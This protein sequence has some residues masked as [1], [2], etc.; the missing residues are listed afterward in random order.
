MGCRLR[1]SIAALAIVLVGGLSLR[2][3]DYD[4]FLKSDSGSARFYLNT[5]TGEFR[6][7]DSQKKLDVTGTGMLYFPSLGP[8][9]FSFAGTAPGY[10]WVSVSLKIYGTAATG[11]LAAFPEGEKVR[12][13]VSN[14]YDRNTE[15]DQPVP[16]HRKTPP[17]PPSIETIKPTPSEVTPCPPTN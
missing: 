16:K 3:A 10:D 14:L 13:I 17:P 8:I 7:E 9:I 5:R 15:D 1:L 6:W 4:L 11:S 12:K 2:A